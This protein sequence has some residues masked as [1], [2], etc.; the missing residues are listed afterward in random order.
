MSVVDV[1]VGL[2]MKVETIHRA[3]PWLVW[4]YGTTRME[5]LRGLSDLTILPYLIDNGSKGNSALARQASL[6]IIYNFPFI[7]ARTTRWYS[8]HHSTERS[9]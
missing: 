5:H 2:R 7:H 4:L 8:S 6:G 9:T 3:S 1:Q